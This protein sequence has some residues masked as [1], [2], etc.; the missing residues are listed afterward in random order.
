MGMAKIRSLQRYLAAQSVIK[1][2]QLARHY[3]NNSSW[4]LVW[5]KGAEWDIA[6]VPH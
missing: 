2:V 5:F 6:V 3:N 1:Y 4:M